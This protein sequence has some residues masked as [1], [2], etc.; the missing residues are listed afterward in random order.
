MQ[1]MIQDPE[2]DETTQSDENRFIKITPMDKSGHALN[3]SESEKQ[4]PRPA[5]TPYEYMYI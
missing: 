3:K 5:K 4:I 2:D 1:H